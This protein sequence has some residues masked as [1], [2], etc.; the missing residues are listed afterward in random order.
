VSALSLD[1]VPKIVQ[2]AGAL[3]D[4]AGVVSGIASPA[5]KIRHVLLVCDPAMKA[6]GLIDTAARALRAGGLGVSVFDEVQSDPT[7]AQTDATALVARTERAQAVVAMGGGS[8]MDLGKTVAAIAAATAPASHYGLCA[9]PF[10][11]ARLACVCVPTTSGTGSEA[12]RTAV[13]SD[14]AH[15]KVWL[16]GDALKADVILLDPVLT[17]G[18]PTHL[19][20]ATGI[21]ALVHAIE[22]STN[23]NA[24]PANDMYCHQAIRLVVKHLRQAVN[25]P[26]DLAARAGLQWAATFAGIGIDNCGTAI[27]HNIG[28]ALASLRPVHHGRAVGL[29]MR[30][31]LDWSVADKDAAF[32]AAAQ[33]MG[34]TDDP[35]RLPGAFER[36]LRQ[37]GIKVSLAGEGHDAITPAQLAQQMAQ[38]ENEP[39]RRSNRREVR[40]QD[41]LE[42]ATAVLTAY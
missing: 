42:F 30:A 9:N 7:M 6:L 40:E 38:P 11:A 32:A 27:A 2:G 12:T 19:T 21:D 10:P 5:G 18:L 15:R 29:A 41:L 28:H 34:E 24:N 14:A 31:T 36:L 26:G 33:A 25:S 4:L 37:V 13:L 3:E 35:R 8:A 17:T 39:M 20:A 23:R 16:W 1:R 22:A